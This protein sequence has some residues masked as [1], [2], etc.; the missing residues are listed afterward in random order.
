MNR[1]H[2][3]AGCLLILLVARAVM[4]AVLPLSADEAYY[5]LWSKHLALGYYDHPPAIAW[6]IAGG[7]SI[8]GDTAIGVRLA[9][10]LLSLPASWFVWDSARILLKDAGGTQK[11]A[12]AVLA[13]NL[14]LM[15]SVEMLAATPDMPSI[16]ASAATFWALCKVYQTEKPGWWLAVG[17]AAGLGLLSK[18]SGLFLGA[19]IVIW[20]LADTRQRRWLLTPWPWAGAVLALA[21]FAPNLWW[22]AHHDWQTFAF[23]FA[24]VDHGHFTLRYLGEFFAAQAGLATPLIFVLMVVGLW[25]GRKPGTPLFLPAVLAFTA[26]AYFL[27]HALHA[28]VQGNWPCFIYPM[29]SVL[30]AGAFAREGWRRWISLAALPLAALLLVA[31]YAQAGWGV[32]A[33]KH[34]P[35]ARILG[36]QFRPVAQVAAAITRAHLAGAIVTTDY[37]VTA[38]LRFY[39]PSV[40]V[41]Q[42][43]EP[44]RY[45]DAPAPPTALLTGRLIYLTSLK[46]D[47]HKLV[48]RDFGLVGFPTQI[49]AQIQD[50]AE[51]YMLYPVA[52]PKTL[53]I[54]K[55]P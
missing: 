21:V 10:V 46:R 6:L 44:Q 17:A 40:K 2:I 13:F 11:A 47:Q 34:D 35:A 38:W 33:I 8:A 5:W 9:A 16:V 28:R 25:K 39:E 54:G 15:V 14:T 32:I 43:N 22:Q 55:M 52:K 12:I 24:R 26:I 1:T 45:P 31:A 53:A 3:F 23:Q 30:A 19:A 18:F 42:M 51:P 49:Q 29:L 48:E 27:V 4:A 20:L 36:R 7:T 37:E 41:I 50:G